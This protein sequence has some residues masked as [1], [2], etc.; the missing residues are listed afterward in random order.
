[1]LADGLDTP[2]AWEN[3][4]KKLSPAEWHARLAGEVGEKTPLLLDVRNT[5]ES[6]VFF[7][8]FTLEPRFE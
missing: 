2:L 4:G 5:Y 8:F 3:N 1:M 7:F 6:Q